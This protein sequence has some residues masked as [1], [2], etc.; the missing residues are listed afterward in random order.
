MVHL[1]V[2]MFHVIY[3]QITL[4]AAFAHGQQ[5][6]HQFGYLP[7]QHVINIRLTPVTTL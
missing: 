3:A 2:L 4:C 6:Q 5:V 1:M 7:Q